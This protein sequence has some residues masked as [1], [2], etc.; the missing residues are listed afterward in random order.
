L[1]AGGI[2]CAYKFD[3]PKSNLTSISSE[4]CPYERCSG[5]AFKPHGRKGEIKAVSDMDYG[6]VKTHR[7]RCS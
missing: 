6:K 5:N 7:Y 2:A 4:E 1:S 3:D